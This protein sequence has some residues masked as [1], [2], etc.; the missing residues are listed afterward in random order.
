LVCFCFV[1]FFLFFFVVLFSFFFLF[2]ADQT[3]SNVIL[4]LSP[5][6]S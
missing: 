6:E 3:S 2:F 1:F 5:R 4:N